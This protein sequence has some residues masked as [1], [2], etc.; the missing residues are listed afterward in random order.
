MMKKIATALLLST[1]VAAPAFA[2]DAGF[3]A[4]VTL[5]SG[6]IS[7]PA[8]LGAA[9]KNSDTI[10]GGLV[11]YQLDQNWGVEAQY[12]GIGKFATATGSGKADALGVTAVGT[13]PLSDAFSLYGKLGFAQVSGKSS[14]GTLS[15]ANRTSATYGLGVQYNAAP[16]VGIRFG[17]DRFGAAV[18]KAGVK[19]NFDSNVYTVGAVFKF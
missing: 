18:N 3:Y 19:Q 8:A 17:W 12:T 6:R 9:T 11:G 13:L 14:T 10:Y 16:N 2:A 5:G 15:N 1:V 4:G 7:V